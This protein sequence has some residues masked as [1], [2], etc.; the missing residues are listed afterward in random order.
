MHDKT[1]Q[2]IQGHLLFIGG[3]EDRSGDMPVLSHFIE[4]AGGTDQPIVIVTAA[5]EL[6]D[7]VWGQYL[8]AFTELGATSLTHMHLD[9]PKEGASERLLAPL[10]AA[11]GIFMTGGAQKRLMEMLRDTPLAQEMRVAFEQRGAC[12]AGTSAGA[13]AMSQLMLAQG[14]AELEPEKGV[15]ALE[16]GLGFVAQIV[17]DQHFAQ[18]GR[19]PR[20]LSVIAEHSDLYGVGIDE[21]TALAIFPGA[22]IEVVGEGGITL[23]DGRTMLSNIAEIGKH[24][25]P[26]LID[27]R[28]HVL[29]SETKYSADA[30]EGP[31]M[32]PEQF[33]EF[34]AALIHRD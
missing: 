29:P 4:L 28:L 22:G 11:K 21:N 16:S 20:L 27:L 15:V 23:V 10:R 7:E 33:R 18:R 13:S 19:L 9:S 8:A 12:I 30:T 2:H 17:L 34:F 24:E 3:S 14:K 5:S 31:E 1:G 32:V 25:T 6:P 26:R